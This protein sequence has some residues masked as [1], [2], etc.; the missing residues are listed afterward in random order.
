MAIEIV[1][2]PINS[3]M[4]FHSKMLV[5]QRV[6]WD[7][8]DILG[9]IGIAGSYI[10]SV[11]GSYI[12]SVQRCSKSSY[13]GYLWDKP[14]NQGLNSLTRVFSPLMW[15]DPPRGVISGLLTT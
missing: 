12:I 9:F 5:H 10:I 4:I 14:T 15:D 8:W 3:M 6:Y 13:M 1:D 11:F 7:I 2:F